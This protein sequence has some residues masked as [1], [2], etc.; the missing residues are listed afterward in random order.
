MCVCV[1]DAVADVEV[2]VIHL[3]IGLND[4]L[5]IIANSLHSNYR[6]MSLAVCNLYVSLYIVCRVCTHRVLHD[7]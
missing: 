4:N 7:A 6:F 2:E 1:C 5:Q 3:S